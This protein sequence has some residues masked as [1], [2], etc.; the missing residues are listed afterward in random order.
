MK[1]KHKKTYKTY[2]SFENNI[3]QAKSH[4]NCRLAKTKI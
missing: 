2:K 1:I 3:S 4:S